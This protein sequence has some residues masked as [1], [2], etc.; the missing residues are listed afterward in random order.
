MSGSV[1]PL[2]SILRTASPRKSLLVHTTPVVDRQPN[3]ENLEREETTKIDRF[4][5]DGC[6]CDLASGFC[7][8]TFTAEYICRYRCQC[9]E[10]TRTESDMALLGRLAAFVNTSPITSHSTKHCH[11][12]ASRQRSYMLYFH[13]GKRVFRKTF[14]F[15]HTI[16]NK[17]L[18]NLQ[19]SCGRMA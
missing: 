12:L 15:L 7:S 16:S 14:L 9:S 11:T 13:G 10:L 3:A 18:R 2:L 19:E 6:G 8:N 4:L 1:L 5:A 17:R